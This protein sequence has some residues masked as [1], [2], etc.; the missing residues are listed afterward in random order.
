[1]NR[2]PQPSDRWWEEHRLT[3][4]GS[5]TKLSEPGPKKEAPCSTGKSGIPPSAAKMKVETCSISTNTRTLESFW[6]STPENRSVAEVIE[7]PDEALDDQSEQLECPVCCRA[8][9]TSQDIWAHVNACLDQTERTL[10]RVEFYED[11]L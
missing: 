8:D 3:C 11:V 5:F 6:S 2:P 7:I 1:M 9:F 10:P 4:A